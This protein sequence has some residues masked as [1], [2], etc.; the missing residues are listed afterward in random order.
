MRVLFGAL[1]FG[2]FRN[3]E[4]A[5][6]RLA[7]R[8]HQVQLFADIHDVLG[9]Q[10]LVEQLA[11]SNPNITWSFAPSLQSWPWARLARQVRYGLECLRF[12]DPTYD[13]LSKYRR[14]SETKAPRVIRWLARY[15]PARRPAGALLRA[16]ERGIP[17]PSVLT[18]WLSELA[19]DVVLLGSVTN[20]GAPQMDHLKAALA[21]GLRTSLPI[22]SWDH[23]SGKALLHIAPSQVLV[24]NEMQEREARDMHG[25]RED[26]LVV[27]G[28]YGYEQWFGRT[29]SRTRDDFCTECGFSPDHPIIV[30]VCSV[31]SRPA[32]PEAP[33]VLE[34]IRSLRASTDDRLRHAGVVVRPHP[35][36]P[37]DWDNVGL[38]GLG[39]VVIRGRNPI[40]A[41]AKAEYFDSLYHASAVV[42][43]ITS[44]F[45]EA[46]VV[47]RSALT[48]EDPRFQEHQDASPHYHYLRD[49]REGLLLTAPNCAE[50]A[51]QLVR[52]VD[53]D[54]A[55]RARRE[56]FVETFVRAPD[57]MRAS[58]AFVDAVE[59]LGKAP[60]PAPLRVAGG[61][62][63][64]AA[65][66]ARALNA[67]PGAAALF[68]NEQDEA[69]GRRVVEE[70]VEK[71][72]V[73]NGR[74]ARQAEE[75]RARAERERQKA[76]R[77]REKE[78]LLADRQD[79]RARLL[80]QRERARR[81]ARA[82]AGVKRLIADARRRLRGAGRHRVR[83]AWARVKGGIKQAVGLG[84]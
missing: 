5:I 41:D 4:P 24:W 64:A 66:A 14:R 61:A 23:L 67:T 25:L 16:L 3:Y 15:P 84:S 43:V 82:K 13:R 74:L 79:A 34:W 57:G 44:A 45:I 55:V 49:E 80:H 75:D 27:T 33:F 60:A 12:A 58:E 78:K 26:R 69:V 65:W 52:V 36:R 2:C 81:A 11:A 35:E 21:A 1:H 47:G 73:V 18:R 76:A 19:P 8:G 10:A 17:P 28:A 59:R 32:P 71:R 50:H 30:Y 38:D 42:G 72:A 70:R 63:V 68:W 29:P 31:L 54:E 46:A 51:R 53:G 56:R 40:D 83:K 6:R 20:D 37:G 77:V 22:Y 48:I 9:G 7:D 62:A 39:P